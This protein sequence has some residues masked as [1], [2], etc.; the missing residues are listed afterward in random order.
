MPEIADFSLIGL[1]LLSPI[2][3]EFKPLQDLPITRGIGESVNEFLDIQGSFDPRS[4]G[5]GVTQVVSSTQKYRMR[6]FRVAISQ[7]EHW[8]TTDPTAAP[9]SGNALVAIVIEARL[10]STA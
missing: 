3:G 8:V 1:D 10:P 9:P 5:E 2:K 4:R 7:Y 6:G